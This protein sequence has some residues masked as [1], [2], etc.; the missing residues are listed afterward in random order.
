MRERTV[1]THEPDR[2]DEV[3]RDEVR[4]DDVRHDDTPADVRHDDVRHEDVR[5]EEVRRDD[6]VDRD[7]RMDPSRI[8]A[9]LAGIGLLVL[10]TVVLLDT[11]FDGWPS[12]PVTEV[13]NLQHTPLLG[14]VDVGLGVLLLV[15][16]ATWSRALSTFTAALMIAAGLVAIFATEDLPDELA[17]T[18][19]YGWMLVIVG[20]IVMVVDFVV[21]SIGRRQRVVHS[22]H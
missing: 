4:H 17:T 6:V 22:A 18:S 11:G 16:A 13:A 12:E 3:P 1:E 7:S 19:D 8:V 2:V 5:H 20:A 10:G 21:P 15:A 14:V 9:M